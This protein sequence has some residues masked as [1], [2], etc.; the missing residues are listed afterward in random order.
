MRGASRAVSTWTAEGQG[1]QQARK[2]PGAKYHLRTEDRKAESKCSSS[3][4]LAV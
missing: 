3:L 2:Q 1:D 4:T